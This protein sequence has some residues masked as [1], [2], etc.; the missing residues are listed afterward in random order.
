[1]DDDFEK[2]SAEAQELYKQDPIAAR[3]KYKHDEHFTTFEQILE[4]WM[5]G[6]ILL[7]IATDALLVGVDNPRVT[8]VVN[9]HLPNFINDIMQVR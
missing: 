8:Y 5:S 6:E 7:L 4:G 9:Y 2:V 1:M 3:A